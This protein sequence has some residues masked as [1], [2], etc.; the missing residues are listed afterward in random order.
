MQFSGEDSPSARLKKAR[1]LAGKSVTAAASRLGRSRQSIHR[2]ESDPADVK[3]GELAQLCGFYETSL[4]VVMFGSNC[5]Q[6]SP[7]ARRL[8][9][10]FDSLP[11]D[12]RQRWMLLW[13]V[14]GC[15]GVNDPV[16]PRT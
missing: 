2:W 15:R 3:A 6:L 14:M 10:E 11:P 4:D 7:D 1:K 8:A 12:L 5:P 16:V 13:Q 9:A